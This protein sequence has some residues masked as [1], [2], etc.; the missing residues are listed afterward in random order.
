MNSKDASKAAD[1]VGEQSRAEV[2]EI[3]PQRAPDALMRTSGCVQL[4][5]EVLQGDGAGQ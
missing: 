5:Q 3:G 2:A 4:S 1:A